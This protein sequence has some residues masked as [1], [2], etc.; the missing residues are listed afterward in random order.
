MSGCLPVAAGGV[1]TSFARAPQIP[2]LALARLKGVDLGPNIVA[3]KRRGH[4]KAL[5]LR[6]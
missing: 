6:T 5:G 2:T 4:R 3:Y 1:T